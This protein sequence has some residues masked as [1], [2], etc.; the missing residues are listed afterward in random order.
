MGNEDDR[1]GIG[2]RDGYDDEKVDGEDEELEDD[3]DDDD[4]SEEGRKASQV[5]MKIMII[6]LQ[7]QVQVH[8]TW[9]LTRR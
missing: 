1:A 8:Q 3:D 9:S 5:V 2:N 6:L 4:S 7:I